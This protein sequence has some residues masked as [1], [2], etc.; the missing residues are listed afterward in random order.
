MSYLDTRI[1]RTEFLKTRGALRTQEIAESFLKLFDYFCKETYKKNGDEVILDIQGAIKVDQNYDR[2]FRLCN[3]FVLWL[4]EDHPE[5]V[6]QKYRHAESIRKHK[7]SSIKRIIMNLRQYLEEFGQ[8]EFSERRFKRMVK[9]PRDIEEELE[10]FTK[11]EIRAF[12]EVSSPKRRALYM[13]LKDSGM[14]IGEAIRLRKRDVDLTS[15]PVTITI[16]ANYTKT[17][18]GRITFVTRE[19]RPL[20]Q[21]VLDKIDDDDL[22]FGASE[23]YR[24]SLNNDEVIFMRAREKLGFTQRYESNGRFKKNLHSLRAYCAT[25]LADMF[26]EEFAHG[27]IGHKGYL[28]QYIRNKDKLAEKYLRAENQLMIYETVEVV[29]SDETVL[30]MQH[31]IEKLQ[32]MILIIQNTKEKLPN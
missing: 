18:R 4:G 12:I 28:K 6:V 7:P 10:P 11:E 1:T 21:R 14:R 13:T 19:T 9:I 17:K 2:L 29:N 5:I 15:N 23:N 22:I 32:K 27:F 31:D 26:G 8:M 24:Q 16:Q 3:S 30:K 20:L 25:H